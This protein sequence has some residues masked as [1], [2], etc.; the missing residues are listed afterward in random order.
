MKNDINTSTQHPPPEVNVKQQL[1]LH[2]VKEQYKQ[3]GEAD[4]SICERKFNPSGNL[5][6]EL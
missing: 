3:V 1:S 5:I 6:L 2:I 4:L